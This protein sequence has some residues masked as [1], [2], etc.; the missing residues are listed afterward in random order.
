MTSTEVWSAEAKEQL[1]ARVADSSLFRKSPRLR[2]FLRYAGD[3]TLGNRL[4]DLREQVIAEKVFQRKAEYY[5]FQDSIVRAEARNLRKR[6]E[7]YFETE[8]FE[9]AVLI[10]MPKG[11]YSLT[12]GPRPPQ[13]Q[14]ETAMASI[15]ET[16][17]GVVTEPPRLSRR[18]LASGQ[19]PT[20]STP[21]PRILRV[22]C[23]CLGILAT[24]ASTLALHWYLRVAGGP[25]ARAD[26]L[27]FSALF[28]NKQD[29]FIIT[30]DTAFLQIAELEGR[31]LTL[32]DYLVR[33]YPGV[34]H[35]FPPNLI[36]DWNRSQYTDGAET[37]IAGL[38]MKRNA[39]SLQRTFLRS[40]RQVALADFK[41]HN[42]VLLGSPISN[43][44]AEL[45]ANRLNFQFDFDTK[46][47]IKFWNRS[48]HKGELPTYPGALDEKL[49]RTYAQV[50]FLPNTSPDSGSALLL[51]GTTA[52]STAA[53]GEFLLNESGLAKTLKKIGVD[54]SGPPRYFEIFLRATT[55]V[56]DAT[57]S[58]VIAYRLHP[59]SMQ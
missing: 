23:M 50:A 14:P 51:A 4:R 48:P 55:F 9:E 5:D 7:K 29:T 34:P 30:S 38:I 15:P 32:N 36:Q 28:D 18:K 17:A 37:T 39:A 46:C 49:N 10:S 6:L 13:A 52:E 47:G 19:E 3:C 40:G 31:R 21:S 1:I 58:E 25:P 57:Q 11:G 53:A 12:F 26:T 44:W 8:G 27:P 42:V 56:G 54:P 45:Y 33:A 20:W 41:N 35:L 16:V 59:Y 22:A 2:E 24:L 43:P